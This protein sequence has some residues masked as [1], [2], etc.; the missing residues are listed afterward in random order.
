ML[1]VKFIF[2]LPTENYQVNAIGKGFKRFAVQIGE[3]INIV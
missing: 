2:L 3:E 1:R